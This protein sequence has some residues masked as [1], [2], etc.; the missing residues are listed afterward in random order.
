VGVA[1]IHRAHGSVLTFA[2]ILGLESVAV[3]AVLAATAYA[4]YGLVAYVPGAVRSFVAPPIARTHGP[5]DREARVDEVF[6]Q[7][8]IGPDH[9]SLWG[10]IRP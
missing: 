8:G 6:R 4:L 2:R 10:G 1:V 7:V 3:F 9:P 5:G